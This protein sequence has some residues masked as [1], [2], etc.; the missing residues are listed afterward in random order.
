MTS[1]VLLSL[2]DVHKVFGGNHV[3][4]GI[5]LDVNEH[6]V[7]CLI[8]ASGCGKSTLLRCVNAL[9]TI[10]RGTI[11]FDG[12]RISG[13]GIDLD[14][15][16]RDL[17][18]V[19]Q[20]FNLFPHKTV[21]DNITLAPRKVLKMPRASAEA[22]AMQLLERIGLAAKSGAYP[23]QLSGGQQQRV[24]IVRALAMQPRVM[25]LDEITSA[26]DPELVG[27]VLTI[28]RELAADGMTMILAT[29]EMGF[30]KEV[31]SKVCFLHEGRVLEE[32][33]PE[34]LFTDPTE[35]RT[36]AFLKRVI[37]AGRL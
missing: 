35:E 22:S 7:V 25:L 28:V 2:R 1:R 14:E 11:D 19:F 18:I 12:E 23:D 20:Q 9:E 33:P 17:G 3:L 26:L 21:M 24:A 27:E 37:E 6:E 36:Q 5:N 4:K 31:A 29:H 8:G 15:L 34:Q 32:G 16:R 10:D 30:A 13:P